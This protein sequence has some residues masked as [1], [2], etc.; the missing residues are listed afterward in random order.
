MTPSSTAGL[1]R[2]RAHVAAAVGA[3]LLLGVSFAFL[4]ADWQPHEHAHI[5]QPAAANLG[6]LAARIQASIAAQHKQSIEQAWKVDHHEVPDPRQTPPASEAPAI[7]SARQVVKRWLQGYEPYEVDKPTAA[8]NDDLVATSTPGF[9][10]SL[11]AHPPL[12][13]A[14]QLRRGPP[15]G[16]FLDLLTKIAAGGQRARVYVEVAYGLERV[17]FELTL[18]RGGGQRWLVAA[19][20]V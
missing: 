19:F 2:Q 12:I 9:A 4:L 5:T 7:E 20:S 6:G 3:V 16:R 13:P 1:A 15:Q 18:K 8:S 17:G 11:L 10:R 14:A